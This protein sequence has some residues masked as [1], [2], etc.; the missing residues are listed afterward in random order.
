MALPIA[1][2]PHSGPVDTPGEGAYLYARS[3]IARSAT[4][5]S[6]YVAMH[7]TI[8][9]IVRAT[10][11]SIFQITDISGV[12]LLHTL[13]VIQAI[14]DEPDT[15]SFSIRPQD[16]TGDIFTVDVG[17]EIRITAAPGGPP[18]FHGY[19]VVTQPDWRLG[20][21]QPP[22]L[23]VQCQDAMWRFDARI[24]TY[25]FP[26]QSVSASIAHLVRYFCNLSP[27][28]GSPLD[29][30]LASVQAGMPSIPAFDV[31][32][33]RPSTVMRTL[34]AAVSGGFYIE[35]LTVHAWANSVSEPNQTDPIPLNVRLKSLHAFRLTT[36]ATQVR[37]RVIVEGRRTSTLLGFPN[38]S[39]AG[40]NEM[41][42]PVSDATLF[43]PAT[44]PT[45][46][47]Q[48]RIGTQWMVVRHPITVHPQ[49]ANPPK[50][51]PP[52]RMWWAR[53]CSM[54]KPC[55]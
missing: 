26:T 10:D 49:G 1:T 18:I 33:Q 5:R 3:G 32:N 17:H 40:G 16:P 25:R 55:P 52:P 36:D 41:G 35:G 50:P 4:T 39:Q 19:V 45:A 14:N 51:A 15:C 48:A 42:L 46:L 23:A 6:N 11:G 9:W 28:T 2:A 8:E 34:M 30:S 44:G 53:G 37:K 54:W 13:H 27:T 20:N 29:F 21:A 12:V 38:M 7:T 24:V 22:W 43:A 47:Y 31:V